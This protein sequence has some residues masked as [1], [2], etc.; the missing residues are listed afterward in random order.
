VYSEILGLEFS[1]D[2]GSREKN[3]GPFVTP[4][5]HLLQFNTPSVP[6]YNAYCF[7][8]IVS[9]YKRKAVFFCK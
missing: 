6:F 8:A 4:G 5:S 3:F 9:E 7:F 2:V 1:E